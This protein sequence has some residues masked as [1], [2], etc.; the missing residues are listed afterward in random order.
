MLWSW[1]FKK[2]WVKML[3][4]VTADLFAFSIRPTKDPPKIYSTTLDISLK[5]RA[6]SCAMGIGVPWKI[7]WISSSYVSWVSSYSLIPSSTDLWI[8]VARLSYSKFS[9]GQKQKFIESSI[10]IWRRP[11]SRFSGVWW[12]GNSLKG[13]SS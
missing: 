11:L 3:S 6:L 10:N 8:W 7:L 12:W 1:K 5:I 2:F 9:R 4:K 13:I